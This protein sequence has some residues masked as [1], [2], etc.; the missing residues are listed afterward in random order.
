MR[1]CISIPLRIRCQTKNE[2][3]VGNALMYTILLKFRGIEKRTHTHVRCIMNVSCS[4]Q[5]WQPIQFHKRPFSQKLQQSEQ[6]TKR[7]KGQNENGRN[8]NGE[9]NVYPTTIQWN[10]YFFFF[11]FTRENYLPFNAIYLVAAKERERERGR[12][13]K[14]ECHASTYE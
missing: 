4:E 8:T 14:V 6:C 1:V 3:L 9:E 7:T 10:I 11:H 5:N 13:R 12:Q 2:Y